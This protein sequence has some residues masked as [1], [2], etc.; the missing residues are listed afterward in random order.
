MSY[1]AAFFHCVFSTKE[2][3]RLITPN[4]QERLWP[5]FGGIARENDMKALMI[6]GTEDHTHILISL[7][8]RHGIEY[9]E[10]YLWH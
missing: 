3:Q 6:G 5:F 8:H 1:V 4:L 10:R 7:L 9:D 2:R